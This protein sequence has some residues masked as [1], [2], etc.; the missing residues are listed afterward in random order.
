MIKLNDLKKWQYLGEGEVA[1]FAKDDPRTVR[2]DFNAPGGAIL[3]IR[4]KDAEQ[5][6][7]VALK[8]RD[9][10]EFSV[11]GAFDVSV[12]DGVWFYTADS[13]DWTV[14]KVKHE[15][16]TRIVERRT[17]NPEMEHMI[18]MASLNMERRLAQQAD[19]LQRQF[20][21]RLAR[22]D[23]QERERATRERAA[24]EGTGNGGDNRT[25]KRKDIADAPSL[26]P[27]DAS[28]DGRSGSKAK[29]K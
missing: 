20:E 16:F 8:G 24:S 22:R 27:A 14:E 5:G 10:L 28:D 7:D 15:S 2:V 12:D 23:A 9:V 4:E 26:E 18:Y 13:T 3:S 19:E 17:R 1:H 21:R 29:P 25:T 6:F 11:D